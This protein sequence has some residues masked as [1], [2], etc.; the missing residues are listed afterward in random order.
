M[1]RVDAYR[2][3]AA[4]RHGGSFDGLA[5]S[6]RRGE[7]RG[8]LVDADLRG[9]VVGNRRLHSLLAPRLEGMG[10]SELDRCRGLLVV[11]RVVRFGPVDGVA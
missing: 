3:L 2:I 8:R 1:V 6:F 4:D 7:S 5:R 11:Q 10:L 9:M